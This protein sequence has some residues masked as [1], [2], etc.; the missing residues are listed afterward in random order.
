MVDVYA[1][2]AATQGYRFGADT[3]WQRE[4]E[5]AFPYQETPDQLAA[6]AD[7]KADMQSARPMDRLICGDVGFGKTEVA[8]RAIFKCVSD[9]KQAA[10]LVP[11]TLLASQHYYNLKDRFEKFPFKVEMLSRF[12]NTSQQ[13]KIL[14]GL[15]EG[16]IDFVIGTHRLLSK[17]VKFR[18]LGLLVVDEEQR[19]GVK[20]KERI[21]Q[22]R[23]N[24]DV[25]TLSATP[26]PRTLHMSLS[27]IKDMSTIEEPPEDR[28]PVQTYVMEQDD[29]MIRDAVEK[30][31]SRGGQVYVLY[32]RVASIDQVASDIERLVPEASV[33]TGHGKM[34]EKQLENVIL[35]FTNGEY[36]V[37]VSTTIIE[38]GMD[39][40]NVNTMIVLDA[41][42]FGLAQLYQLRG[43]VGRSGRMAYAYLM[44]KKDKNL[45]EIA[46]K[47]LRAI[48][49]FTEFGSGFK[50]AMKDLEFRGAGNLL[51]TEQSGHMLNVGY[52]LYCKMLE[53]AVNRLK[54]RETIPQAE[55]TAFSL[56]VSAVIPE[57]Y[58][59]NEVLR[60][61]MYKKIAM[62]ASDEDEAEMID[63]L[64]DRF[65]DIPRDTMNL[66]K[67]SKIRSMAGML[68]VREI[69]QQ[70]Y[71]IIFRLWE[72]VKPDASVM[73]ALVSEYGERLMINGGREPYIRLTINRDE[74]V[75]AIEGF[76]KT[77]VSEKKIN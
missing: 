66:I 26:I 51:G 76:L 20:H 4:M 38:S 71:K 55:E 65:G 63:E 29:F 44:Y 21:K 39:I 34:S 53:E 69:L 64:I 22:I 11:T 70:G 32:N 56:P 50:I 6:I 9:G 46:E 59:T 13:K 19:F 7:V 16:T 24:V 49:E 5:V 74:P 18:D 72:N 36:N 1:R 3:P 45:T 57:R 35:D 47:R 58:I 17:D 67:I 48:K 27:G 41:D 14:K 62:V 2:R 68:G 33:V 42:R 73:A 61:Q 60:L 30:E 31:L 15:E 77:A 10:V 40:P 37:L 28:Y 12:R 54:G 43:R 8:A 23:E 75:A 52:E 25:L